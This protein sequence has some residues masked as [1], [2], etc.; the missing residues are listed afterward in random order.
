MIINQRKHDVKNF[1]IDYIA[2]VTYY[3]KYYLYKQMRRQN[4]FYLVIRLYANE[5][6][7]LLLNLKLQFRS[8]QLTLLFKWIVRKLKRFFRFCKEQ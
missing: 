2:N 7:A 8:E 3:C 1:V 5:L 4:L 6:Y